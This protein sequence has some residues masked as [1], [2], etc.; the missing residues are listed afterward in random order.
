[1]AWA[2]A[3]QQF[4]DGLSARGQFRVSR[5]D[6]LR[7]GVVV[8]SGLRVTAGSVNVSSTSATRRTCNVTLLDNG[9]DLV[10]GNA[11]DPLSVYGNEIA[12]Y[13]GLRLDTTAGAVVPGTLTISDVVPDVVTLNVGEAT[14]SGVSTVALTTTQRDV[15]APVGVFGIDTSASATSGGAVTV[16]ITGS[17]RSARVAR[18]TLTDYLAIPDA[19]EATAGITTVNVAD[20]IHRLIDPSLP[21]N[22]L[23]SFVPTDSVVGGLTYAPQQDRWDAATK[24]AESIGMILSF[25]PSGI[26]TLEPVPDS[27]TTPTVY[28]FAPGSRSVATQATKMLDRTQAANYVIVTAQGSNIDTPAQAVAIDDDPNSPTYYLGTFGTVVKNISTSLVTDA[29]SAQVYANAQLLL[30]AGA[31]Q[32]VSLTSIVLPHLD[33]FDVISASIPALKLSDR[34]VIDQLTIPLG[35]GTMSITTRGQL[36]T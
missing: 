11:T 29:D 23:F 24:L 27:F 7:D 31:T 13:R 2:G 34:F 12:L 1:M 14:G 3:D 16:A 26:C 6:V 20:A 32:Q 15:L 4:V 10:P 19:D 28:A 36:A 33:A 35:A 21:P 9:G 30:L 17:D 18:D 5:A 8:L 25:D 22:Q